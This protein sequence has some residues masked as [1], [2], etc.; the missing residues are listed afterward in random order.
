L[1]LL[2]GVFSFTCF[3]A[4][5]V[6]TSYIVGRLFIILKSRFLQQSQ[7]VI[8]EINAQCATVH[9]QKNNHTFKCIKIFEEIKIT[10]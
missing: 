7:K 4:V 3:F 6:T 8:I 1:L 9:I 5:P 2:F 10:S